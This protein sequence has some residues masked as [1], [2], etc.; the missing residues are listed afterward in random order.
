MRRLMS[1]ILSLAAAVAA[2]GTVQATAGDCAAPAPA[3]N[4][5]QPKKT[6]RPAVCCRRAPANALRAPI[7]K[8]VCPITVSVACCPQRCKPATTCRTVKRTRPEPKV[9]CCS[10]KPATCAAPHAVDVLPVPTGKAKGVP[11]PPAESA[12]APKD[13]A[14]AAPPKD[15]A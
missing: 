5:C 8:K 6:A 11:A 4:T 3:C 15:A 9:T 1:G 7:I 10:P 14:V 12:P 13:D 2:F